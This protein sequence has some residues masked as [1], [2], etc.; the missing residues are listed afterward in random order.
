MS[1]AL[2]TVLERVSG[3]EEAYTLAMGPEL[4]VFQGHFPGNPVLPGV[5]QVDWAIRFGIQAFGPLEGF[6]GVDQLKFQGMIRPGDVV[7]LHL[8]FA[9]DRGRLSFRYMAG[10]ERKSSGVVLFAGA[11]P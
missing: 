8:G 4:A 9:A 6:R 7:E 10:A 2:P 5:V 1:S 3:P 11:R